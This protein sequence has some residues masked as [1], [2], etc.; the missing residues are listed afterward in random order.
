ML[1]ANPSCNDDLMMS[2]RA[3]TCVS[4]QSYQLLQGI[5]DCADAVC[6]LLRL[7]KVLSHQ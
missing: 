7:G 6:V 1:M 5:S 3:T 4:L 2:Y